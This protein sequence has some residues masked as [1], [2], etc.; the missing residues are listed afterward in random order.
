MRENGDIDYTI[1]EGKLRLDQLIH[2]LDAIATILVNLV[3]LIKALAI[4]VAINIFTVIIDMV[5]H[6]LK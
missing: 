2:R 4:M 3:Y 6:T 5:I 1:D